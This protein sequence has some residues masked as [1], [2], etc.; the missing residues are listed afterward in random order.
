MR[1]LIFCLPG[2]GDALMATPMIRLLK[3]EMP[4]TAIDVATMFG[5]VSYL[6]K[7]NSAIDKIYHLPIYRTN[8]F[9]GIKNIFSLQ[10]K[11]YDISILAFPTY[12]REYHIVQRLAGAKRRLAHRFKKGFFSEFHFLNT[13]LI[14]VD[15]NE[16]N[17]INNLNLLKLLGVDW[18]NKHKKD[19]FCY[20]LFL[21]KENTSF[22]EQYL[23]KIGR[24][25]KDIVGIHPGSINSPAGI[26]KRWPID[27]FARVGKDLIKKKKMILIFFGPFEEELGRKLFHLIDD[28]KN[29][30]LIENTT[31]SES[32]GILSK[33]NLLI[34]NDNG[35]AHLANALEVKTIT[36]FG[37]T[38][39]DFCA[40]YNNKLTINLRKANFVPWFKND[41]KVTSL[42]KY[43]ESGMEKIQVKDVIR[44]V[45]TLLK[46]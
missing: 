1:I 35:F 41:M 27:R 13:D 5:T 9:I 31:F 4:G 15:E 42:P 20:E 2:I 32:L 33:L 21:D 25:E 28:K 12:R 38:N 17:V 43:A 30:F 10:K 40:P 37:P 26:F 8:R 18:E 46:K 36:L 45:E 3:N 19:D 23:K 6:F 7:N 24:D 44:S 39:M 34:S 11:H 16:H 29:C 14:P 22:G